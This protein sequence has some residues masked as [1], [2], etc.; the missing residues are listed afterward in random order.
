MNSVGTFTAFELK[1]D[2]PSKDYARI[3]FVREYN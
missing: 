3:G 1:L 2:V